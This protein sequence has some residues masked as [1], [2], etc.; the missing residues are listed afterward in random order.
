M[1][2]G[3]KSKLKLYPVLHRILLE[4]TDDETQHYHAG[5]SW[6][7]GKIRSER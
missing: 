2:T 6:K 4:N 7:N 5:K 1:P 3:N